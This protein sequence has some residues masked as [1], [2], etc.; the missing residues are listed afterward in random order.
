MRFQQALAER[1]RRRGGPGPDGLRIRGGDGW[2]GPFRR[3]ILL[4]PG[5]R[6]RGHVEER[7]PRPPGRVLRTP[8][9]M[10]SGSSAGFSP[11]PRWS[12]LLM[13][14]AQA[15]PD[16]LTTI[17]PGEDGAA[18][19]VAVN[20]AVGSWPSERWGAVASAD[21][22]AHGSRWSPSRSGAPPHAAGASRSAATPPRRTS[23]S[24]T[25]GRPYGVPASRFLPDPDPS[26]QGRRAVG[27]P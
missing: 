8:T 7:R 12:G 21:G 23:P 24:G 2:A 25:S 15:R 5:G 22:S 9:R 17:Y 13:G 20:P 6:V 4:R 19:R 16:H 1:G 27:S 10:S 14:R 11:L 18:R 3:R 26:G